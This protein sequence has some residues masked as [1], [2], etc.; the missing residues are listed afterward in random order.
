MIVVGGGELFTGNNLIVIAWASGKVTSRA[1]LESGDCVRGNCVGAFLTAAL[2]F[3]TTQYS[4]GGGAV[5]L[6]ALGTAN[7][8]AALRN[9]RL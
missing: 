2:M 8:K 3:Y 6:A 1:L 9:F 4:F 5:G 7:D